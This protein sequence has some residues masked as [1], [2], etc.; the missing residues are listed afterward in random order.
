MVRQ[1]H[2][3]HHRQHIRHDQPVTQAVLH[4]ERLVALLIHLQQVGDLEVRLHME[5]DHQA[6]PPAIAHRHVVDILQADV[7]ATVQVGV[8]VGTVQAEAEAVIH[9]ADEVVD[10]DVVAQWA[11]VSI[12]LNS[13]RRQRLLK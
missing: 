6:Q 1:A 11:L 4:E 7:L 2:D 3:D 5:L 12:S 9:Q 13:S 10:M 8:G